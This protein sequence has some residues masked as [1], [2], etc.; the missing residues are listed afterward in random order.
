MILLIHHGIDESTAFKIMEKVRKGKGITEEEEKLMKEKNI[1]DWFIS[2]CKK[3]KYLFP[4]A[5]AVAYVSMA[6]RI[7]YFKVH[8]PLAYYA[9]FF[10]IKGGEFPIDIIMKGPKYIRKR[11]I[12]LSVGNKKDVKE[13]NEEKV[14]EA[15]LEMYLR[16]IQFLPPDI[17]KSDYRRFLIEEG[18]L[19]IPLNRIPGVGENVAYS[20]IEARKIKPFTSIED[21]KKR[22]K[23]SK[24]HIETMRKLGILDNLDE[25]DQPTLF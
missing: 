24:A 2:S 23:L 7:A 19:R 5:H 25:T 17:F 13:R 9:A 8:Y 4:K 14:L 10:S 12:E 21:L 6:F 3:I 18:R 22:T 16:G 20:I 11:L 15:T 1:P